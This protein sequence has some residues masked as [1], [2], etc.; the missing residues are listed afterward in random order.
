MNAIRP[1]RKTQDVEADFGTGFNAEIRAGR[2]LAVEA[3]LDPR[4]AVNSKV[5]VATLCVRRRSDAEQ[6][7]LARGVVH[8]PSP[9]ARMD[10]GRNLAAREDVT[11]RTWS[12]VEQART[13]AELERTAEQFSTGGRCSDTE[14]GGPFRRA[15]LLASFRLLDHRRRLL[16]A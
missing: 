10:E 9:T 13:D 1:S 16:H 12:T 3:R 2:T 6:R 15:Y 7:R 8:Q 4:T 14:L 11:Q 5:Y